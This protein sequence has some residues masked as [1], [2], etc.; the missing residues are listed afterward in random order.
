MFDFFWNLGSFILALGIL[1]TVH[2]YG[3]FWVARKAGVKVLRFSIGFGKPLLKWHDKYNTE[4]VIAA[5]PLG[6]YVK[7]LDERVDEVPAN[8]RHL[9]FNAK[10]VQARIAIVAAGPMANFLFA[11]FALAVMYMVGVQTIKPV[12][13][14]VVEGSRAEQAGIMPTQQIIK[15]GDDDIS[16]W[17]DATFSLMSH[18]GDKSVAVTLR[19]ENYQQTV[20]TL[21]LDGWKLDQ[22][23]V[24][25]LS[26]LGIVPFRPQA[27][28]VIAAITKNSAAEQANLQVNDVILAVNGETMS[29]WQQLVNLITQSANKSLQFSVKRQDSIKTITVTPKSRVVSNGIE[30]G[31]LGVAPVVEQWPDDFVETRHYGP[32][33]SIVLGTKETWRLITLSF[34]MIGNLIT[35]QV[36][37]KNLSGPVGIAVGAGTSVSYGLVAFLSF[38]A[39]ISVNLGVFNLLPLPVL[40][41]GHLMY[42]IIELF[43]KKPVSEK[44]QEFGFK[45]GALLLIFLTCFALFN[46]VSRL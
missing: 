37:V 29:S 7:M 34:D 10:S 11:I 40:D 30:Q 46:D 3:H 24:P 18:L 9:S 45:V 23:D 39:L 43:R 1:V 20:Q 44:T 38:L 6:G 22:Q 33:D 28:L 16:N 27:T 2:E 5:I 12:V 13:G 15:I 14:S 31:F 42:Y 41:G 32:L 19:N 4:Y 35:G 21:N 26:S 8:Q 36:S 17:Q 25:P